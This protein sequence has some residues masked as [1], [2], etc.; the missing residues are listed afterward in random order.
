MALPRHMVPPPTERDGHSKA[1]HD[2]NLAKY[3]PD[4]LIGEFRLYYSVIIKSW[5]RV[6]TRILV[7]A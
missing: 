7:L 3:I 5:V 2:A 1:L 6:H 4:G